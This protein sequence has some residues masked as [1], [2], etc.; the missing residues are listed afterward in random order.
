MKG[1][2]S[3]GDNYVI[4]Y[5]KGVFTIKVA[6]PTGLSI[7]GQASQYIYGIGEPFKPAG[8]TVTVTYAAGEPKT[9]PNDD[10]DLVWTFDN[11]T[12]S[13]GTNTRDKS[14]TVKYKELP[15][16]TVTEKYIVRTLPWRYTAAASGT[17]IILYANEDI[18]SGMQFDK[19][20]TLIGERSERKIRRTTQG[21]IF[22]VAG[23]NG[24]LTLGANVTLDG[25]GFAN[26]NSALVNIREPLKTINF[27]ASFFCDHFL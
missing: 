4:N 21:V 11:A 22:V 5:T 1:D 8:L 12:A 27:P 14:V 2:L 19:T 6:V 13:A 10:P 9:I 26:N 7:T 15:A 3:A 18:S 24:N 23:S 16:V 25:S 20:I 17:T